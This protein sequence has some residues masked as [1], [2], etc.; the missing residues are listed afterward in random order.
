MGDDGEGGGGGDGW[1]VSA[2]ILHVWYRKSVTYRTRSSGTHI[3]MS[4]KPKS[5]LRPIAWMAFSSWPSLSA[6]RES[7]R[8][9]T[10]LQRAV[11]LS[12]CFADTTGK[13]RLRVD[14][15][16]YDDGQRSTN[17]QAHAQ[18]RHRLESSTCNVIEARMIRC[19]C[20]QRRPFSSSKGADS[21]VIDDLN[22]NGILPT[23][24]LAMNMHRLCASN[25]RIAMS[26]RDC[27][28]TLYT[29]K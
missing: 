1:G 10:P 19:A 3:N 29:L 23:P 17:K 15:L 14:L 25:R 22:H 27:R 9:K 18:D 8:V 26:R 16:R 21:P 28:C 20:V 11:R 2:S 13:R 24:K 4:A 6:G 7:K 12:V 5:K